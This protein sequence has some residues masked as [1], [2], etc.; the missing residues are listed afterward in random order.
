MLSFHKFLNEEVAP[1]AGNAGNTTM[2]DAYEMGTVLHI[3]NNTAAKQNKDKAYVAKISELKKKHK[4]ALSKLPPEKQADV[5]QKSK[6]S[7]TAYLGSLA[8]HEGIKPEHIHEVHHTNLGISSHMGHDVV[9]ADNPHDLII[10]GKKGR[11]KFMHGA[12]LKATCLLYTSDAAD[13]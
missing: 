5:E 3:H 1:A 8:K 12:S 2:G 10:K 13:E 11:S 6:D 4:E 7:A 9:R